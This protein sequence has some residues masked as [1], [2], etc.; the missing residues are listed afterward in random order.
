MT[1]KKKHFQDILM[2]QIVKVYKVLKYSINKEDLT[3]N[4]NHSYKIL[5]LRS[6]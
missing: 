6:Q 1:R 4:Y 5:G 2:S 3:S